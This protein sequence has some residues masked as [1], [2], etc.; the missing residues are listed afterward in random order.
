[1]TAANGA[2]TD[3]FGPLDVHIYVAAP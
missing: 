1:V 3:T 2:F